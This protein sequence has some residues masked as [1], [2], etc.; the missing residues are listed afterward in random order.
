MSSEITV[1]MSHEFFH[2]VMNERPRFIGRQF[3]FSQR[4]YPCEILHEIHEPALLESLKPAGCDPG[5]I[6]CKFAG[7][8]CITD[9][10]FVP[11]DG[12]V[13]IPALFSRITGQKRSRQ[14]SVSSGKRFG[15]CLSRRLLI[16]YAGCP[17]PCGR[18]KPE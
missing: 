4:A 14:F 3:R 15:V 16:Y 2:N 11:S 13:I 8:N 18:L 10:E 9:N 1:K 12:S 5:N 17:V 7:C 6:S